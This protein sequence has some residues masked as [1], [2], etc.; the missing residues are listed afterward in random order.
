MAVM[1]VDD[2]SLQADSL[3]CSEGWQLFGTVECSSDKHDDSTVVVFSGQ[4]LL[5]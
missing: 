5:L 1:G 4:A 2:N 3:T